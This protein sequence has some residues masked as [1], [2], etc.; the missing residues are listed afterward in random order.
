MW[1][2][3]AGGRTLTFH[4]A[5]INNQNFLMRDDETG[6]YWQQVTGRA[7]AGP[8][9]GASLELV[10]TDEVSFAVF[11]EEN[12]TGSVLAPVGTY[13]AQYAKKDWEQGMKRAR[14]VIS[15]PGLSDREL[16]LGLELGNESR[17]YVTDDVLQK[18]VIQDELGGKPIVLVGGPDG[19]S[20]R[21]FV[22]EIG[23]RKAEFFRDQKPEW[24]L[25]DSATGSR[26]D[27][28]GCAVDGPAKGK[29][30]ESIGVLRD[31]WFDWRNYHPNTTVFARRDTR[32][33]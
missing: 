3:T 27:F 33:N 23:D 26:W 32:G 25:I 8:M 17:A 7:I 13:A 16:V 18:Q 2:R 15:F 12:P 30:L 19:K 11:R 4:L 14:T 5:G 10:G 20:V 22:S 6:S 24:A 9:E 31:Y 1:R 29:C 28:R 21:A